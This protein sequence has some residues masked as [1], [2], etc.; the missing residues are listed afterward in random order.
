MKEYKFIVARD[1]KFK[2][3]FPTEFNEIK[4]LVDQYQNEGWDLHKC[5]VLY[6][7]VAGSISQIESSGFYHHLVFEKER[8]A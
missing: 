6:V 8:I 4:K 5:D 3:G 1:T 2:S 7:N